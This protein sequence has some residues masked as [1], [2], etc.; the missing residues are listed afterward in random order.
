ME[1]KKLDAL[2]RAAQQGKP[3][4]PGAVLE[5]IAHHESI[6]RAE[7]F[8]GERAPKMA[9]E[10]AALRAAESNLRALLPHSRH[11]AGTVE[12]AEKA[13]ADLDALRAVGRGAE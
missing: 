9:E 8:W 6:V 1:H 10:L 2:K 5:L 12:G 11:L 7:T 4:D 13:L 3:I